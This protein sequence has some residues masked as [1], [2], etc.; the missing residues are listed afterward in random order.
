MNLLGVVFF[1]L[2]GLGFLV[3]VHELGH[4]LVAKLSGIKVLKFSL[5]FGKKIFGFTRGETEYLISVLPLGGYVKLS[6]EE[7]GEKAPQPGDYFYRPWWV[8]LLVL[9]AGPAM[10]FIAAI[11][12]LALL[13]WIGFQ[14]PVGKPQVISVL[15]NSPAQLAGLQKGDIINKVADKPIA[16]WEE[17]SKHI[18]S[19]SKTQTGGTIELEI[20]RQNK[21]VNILITPKWDE[22]AKKWRLGV[23]VTS[24]ATN[25]ISKVLVGTPAELA[26]LKP[27]DKIISVQ[28]QPVWTR[29]DFQTLIW[30][31][32][33]KI[34]K[35]KIIRETEELEIEVKPIGQKLPQVGKVGIIGVEFK[36]SNIK[37]TVK[38]S[39]LSAM[40]IG[41]KYTFS[42]T[43]IIIGSVFQMISGEISAKD[44]V[45][46]PITIMRMAGQEAKSG[47]KDFFFFLA[48][49]SIMLGILNLL[50]IPVLDGGTAVF[51]IIE[52]IIRKPVPVK[53]QSIAQ[54]IGISLLL[55][56]MC[57]AM[58]N[59]IYKLVVSIVK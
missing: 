15:K 16:S 38:Y 39:F 48:G 51:F 55:A 30:P 44:S 27:G 2:L 9:L 7:P 43:G 17:F 1:G 34:T 13:F 45:G 6:G 58:Y 57:F 50:P 31:R 12:I 37:K 33:D 23:E 56:L 19:I 53:I 32:A 21:L 10:N 46:G 52:G 35:L 8:R 20:L 24:A 42:M 41:Y 5:G 59:D 49:I 14:V 4:F 18:D 11:V 47:F 29:Y 28:D 3:F 36:S 26:R 22:K 40:D 54:K 25:I